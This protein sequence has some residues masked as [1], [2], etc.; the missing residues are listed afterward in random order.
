MSLFNKLRNEFI[1]IIEWVDNTQDTIVWKF[2][3]YQNE[4]KM[5]AQL[6]VREGQAAVFMNEGVIADLFTAGRYE[7]NTQNMPIMTTLRGWKY[8]FN[9]PFKA[10]VFFVSLRQFTNQKW[11]TKNPIML[12]DAEF[13]PVRL[14]AFGNYAFSV[15]DPAIFLKE[16]A[17]TNPDFSVDHINEQ[18]RNLAVSRGMDAIAESKIPVLD[19]ASN[20]DEVSKVI[21]DKISPEFNEIGLNL[22]KFLIENLSL[23][24][25]VEKILDKRSGMGIVGDMGAFAQFQA[26]NSME[27]AAENPNGGGIMGAGMGAGLGMG[28]MGQMGNVFQERKFEGSTSP[29]HSG[30]TVPPPLPEQQQKSIFYV[31]QGQQQG[32]VSLSEIQSLVTSGVIQKETLVWYAGL[33]AWEKAGENAEIAS[34]FQ[35]TPPPIPGV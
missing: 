15:K 14:R 7:L 27:K 12:R 25:E 16:I 19:L 4:I 20:Y 32:P 34:L 18:L 21:Q 33:A 22:N 9:S 31:S 6:T 35:N 8:G 5:G 13:G 3:R 23:P 28:M 29:Q 30:A 11:G 17:A 26:A 24:E 2:P 1:D 10:D